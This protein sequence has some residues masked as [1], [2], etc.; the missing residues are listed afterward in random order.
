MS[1]ASGSKAW[2]PAAAGHH[3]AGECSLQVLAASVVLPCDAWLPLHCP[4]CLWRWP[5]LMIDLG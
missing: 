3:V 5:K 1:V 2:L 4:G